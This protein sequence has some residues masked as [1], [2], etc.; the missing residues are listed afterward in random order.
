MFL[1]ERIRE[2]VYQLGLLR[3]PLRVELSDWGIWLCN[4]M[5]EKQTLLAENTDTVSFVAE[6]F[7]IETILI[8]E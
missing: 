7:A 8:E 1:V 5:E 2:I 3:H 6:P 4:L